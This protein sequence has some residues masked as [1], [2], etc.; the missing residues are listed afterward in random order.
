MKNSVFVL[1]TSSHMNA[2][3]PAYHFTCI[4]TILFPHC[5][6]LFFHCHWID[7]SWCISYENIVQD[8]FTVLREVKLASCMKN[9]N[10]I[11]LECS[12]SLFHSHACV[13]FVYVQSF[14]SG[15]FNLFGHTESISDLATVFQYHLHSALKTLSSG[16]FEIPY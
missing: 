10:S 15:N 3:L 16:G 6:V 7:S 4:I 1:S 2:F 13:V 8:G 12:F 5:W 9:S 14:H 11:L